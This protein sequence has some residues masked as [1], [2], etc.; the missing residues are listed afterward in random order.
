MPAIDIDRQT[1]R[2]AAA[3]ELAKPLYPKPSVQDRIAE[4]VNDL[5]HRLM[6]GG[7]SLPGGWPTLV[8]LAALVLAAVIVAVR[9]ARRTMGRGADPHLYGGRTLS[10]ADHRVRAE[11]AAAQGD[12]A[13][14]IRQ[15]VRAIGRHLEECGVLTAVPGRTAVELAREAGSEL[16]T[17]SEDFASAAGVFNDVSYGEQPGSEQDYRLIV[18]LD[19]RV[20]RESA[21]TGGVS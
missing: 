7:S 1:A 14:A 16:P 11:Q 4:W 2:E 20:G 21:V 17:L 8:V 5:L 9:V 18:D 15:R 19:E 3:R 12:W 13:G 6:V 10:A